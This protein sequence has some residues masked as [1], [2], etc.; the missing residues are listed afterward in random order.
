[1]KGSTSSVGHTWVGRRPAVLQPLEHFVRFLAQCIHLS[2]LAGGLV[3]VFVDEFFQGRVGLS[4]VAVGKVGQRQCVGAPERIGFL[5]REFDRCS[6][7]AAQNLN[8]SQARV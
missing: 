5:F 2:D 6:G 1:M 3:G 7:I 4:A 8:D